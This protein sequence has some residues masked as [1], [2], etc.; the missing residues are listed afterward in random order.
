MIAVVTGGAFIG[1]ELLLSGCKNADTI[2]GV[3]SA[4]LIFLFSMK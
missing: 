2:G 3:I 1:G 4:L